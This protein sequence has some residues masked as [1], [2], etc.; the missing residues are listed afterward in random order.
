MSAV[1]SESDMLRGMRDQ[2]RCCLATTG[3]GAAGVPNNYVNLWGTVII[4]IGKAVE[5]GVIYL[6]S[7]HLLCVGVPINAVCHTSQVIVVANC[8]QASLQ[9]IQLQAPCRI[10]ASSF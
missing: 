7:S 10:V 6:M 8:T 2:F 5:W 3:D 4:W 9:S 1:Q